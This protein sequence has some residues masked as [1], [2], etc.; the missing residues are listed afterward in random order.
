MSL[1]KTCDTQE[2]QKT[3]NHSVLTTAVEDAGDDSEEPPRRERFHRRPYIKAKYNIGDSTLYR[4][5]AEGRFPLSVNLGP[6]VV[7]WRETALSEFDKD[8]EKWAARH[9]EAGA[10]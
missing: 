7:A 9:R 4:W 8:P 5:M 1:R 10:S 6:N 3:E 2:H